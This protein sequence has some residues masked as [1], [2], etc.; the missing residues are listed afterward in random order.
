MYVGMFNVLRMFCMY[1]CTYVG[2][3]LVV[4]MEEVELGDCC[5]SPVPPCAGQD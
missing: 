2:S 5:C 3:S 4:C 1:V